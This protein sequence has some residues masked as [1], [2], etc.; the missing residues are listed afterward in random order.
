MQLLDWLIVALPLLVVGIATFYANRYLK[1]VVDFMSGGRLAG[2]YLLSTARSEMGA[3][4]IAYV[5]FFELFGNGGFALSWWG[6]LAVP[7]T[8][9][10]AISGFVVYRYRQTRALT[11]AQ[12]FEMRY[13]R[14][15][16]LFTGGLAFFA[17]LMN[18]G[19]IPVIGGKFVVYFLGLPPVLVI[20]SLHVPTYL[21]LMAC[22][23]TVT[24]LITITGG[25]ITVMIAD[26]IQ[27]MFSQVFYVI[28]GLALLLMLNWTDARAM[29][30][31]RP[32]GQSMVNPFDS[33]SVKDFN[34]WYVLMGLFGRV[35]STMAWQNNQGF[36]SAAAT[37]HESRMGYIL[38]NWRNF[39]WSTTQLL[40]GV[41]V[42]TYLAQP[43]TAA[44]VQHA[45]ARISDPQ[46]AEQ[47]RLTIGLSQVLPIGIKGLFVS[48][49]LMGIF[50]GDGQALHSWGS[51]LVQDVILPMRKRPL[52][53]S[54][55]I[56]LL[57]ASIIGVAVFAFIFGASFTQTEYLPM[58]FQVTSAIFVG[59]A[60]VCIIGGLYWSRGTTAGAWIGLLTGSIL[61]VG[62]IF[63]RQ[64]AS[65]DFFGYL[66]QVT[67]MATSAWTS[68]FQQHLGARFPF[69]GTEIAFYASLLA[70]A[71]YVLFSLLTCRTPHNM[72][73]LLHRGR[74]ALEPEAPDEPVAVRPARSRFHLYNLVGIDE[75][76]TRGDRWTT[77][78]IFFW[79]L[80]WFSIFLVGTAWNLCFHRWS[81]TTWANYWLIVGLYIPFVISVLTTIWFTIGCWND[82]VLF[83]RRLRSERVDGHDDGTVDTGHTHTAE[84][85]AID[86][87]RAQTV[88]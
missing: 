41:T 36:N 49:V 19:V 9:I 88:V 42:L 16:R 77:L 79:S 58:W 65:V 57:R 25:Q 38:G 35:Y 78:G 67:G 61:S 24:V 50:G 30:L 76:F 31:S 27:G 18:F 32:P 74:Y 52:S 72:D 69:N 80:F 70:I 29:L 86:K 5:S 11:L 23:L 63:L 3:G 1:S 28:I 85:N 47:M 60:G 54:A 26:C 22:F 37:A 73:Q 14:S 33:F 34:I 39:A 84:K 10:V 13:S 43:N 66:A 64:P 8:L 17:G 44:Q 45:L 62:G 6:Q 15:F 2:R 71:A 53:T 55:H 87:A 59:G 40:L 20:S 83:Y 75:H 51:I 81:D 7:A 12:F 56:V 4:A 48:L 82:L 68:Y 46:T 21:V